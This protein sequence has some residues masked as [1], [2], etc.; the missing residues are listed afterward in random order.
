MLLL[1]G[2][3][4]LWGAAELTWVPGG[5]GVARTGA[6]E[7]T[8]LVPVA[9]LSVAAIAAAVALAGWVRVL[10]GV[11]VACAGAAVAAAATMTDGPLA[12]RGLALVGAV[13]VIAAGVVLFARGRAMP[14]LLR[15]H[16]TP[17]A[18]KRVVDPE[19]AFWDALERGDD[20][21]LGRD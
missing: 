13:L 8:S 7:V 12:G 2:A 14:W 5:T 19:R 21:T 10:L 6:Q 20:P 17:G 16:R 3:A 1:A 18:A 15:G 4:A 11:P 9:A